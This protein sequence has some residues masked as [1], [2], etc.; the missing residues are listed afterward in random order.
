M[1]AN[2]ARLSELE[3]V[4][5]MARYSTKAYGREDAEDLVGMAKE[6]VR[7]VEELAGLPLYHPLELHFARPE[8]KGRYLGGRYIRLA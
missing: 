6:V 8:E 4:Y 1:R 3:D 2:R 5:V 7:F